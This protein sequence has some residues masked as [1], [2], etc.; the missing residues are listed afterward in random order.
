MRMLLRFIKWFFISITGIILLLFLLLILDTDA[1]KNST[2]SKA[3]RNSIKAQKK[4]SPTIDSIEYNALLNEFGNKKKLAPGFE[5]QCL[6]ALSHYPQLKK[7]PIDF[8][9]Q[10]AFI[11]LSARPDPITVLLPWVKRRY[12]V[13]ISTDTGSKDDPILLSKAPFNEQVGIIGHELAHIVY[14]LDKNSLHLAKVAYLY[15]NDD[16]F[17]TVFERDTDK[18]AVVHGLG[19]Q[20]YDFAFFVRKAFG[21][22]LEKIVQEKGDTYLSPGEIAQEMKKF[23]FYRDSIT[24]PQEYFTN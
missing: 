17:E 13:V 23:P 6:L 18:R 11:Q 7:V 24:P 5:Y 15:L 22:S 19:Y 20:L 2:L 16:S 8:R 14:Y 1:E 3:A 12:L 21:D 9:V 10:P 4:Y